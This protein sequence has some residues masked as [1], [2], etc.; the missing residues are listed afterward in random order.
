MRIILAERR[1][2]ENDDQP[3]IAGYLGH[4]AAMI[5]MMNR[6]TYQINPLMLWSDQ[7]ILEWDS[8]GMNIQVSWHDEAKTI[9]L[10]TY[11]EG[12]TAEEFYETFGQAAHLVKESPN[13]L[14]GLFTDCTQDGMPPR[15]IM[16]RYIKGIQHGTMPTALAN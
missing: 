12:W 16:A 8:T 15:N 11:L 7:F 2:A 5:H 10:Y 1:M 3:P 9:L 14:R 6:F 4:A 13:R